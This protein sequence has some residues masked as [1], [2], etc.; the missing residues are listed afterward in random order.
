M[1]DKKHRS[2]FCDVCNNPIYKCRCADDKEQAIRLENKEFAETMAVT[3][4]PLS[5]EDY[6]PVY[7]PHED[8]DGAFNGKFAKR[9]LAIHLSKTHGEKATKKYVKVKKEESQAEFDNR[10]QARVDKNKEIKVK[11]KTSVVVVSAENKIVLSLFKLQQ[12]CEAIGLDY[13]FQVKREG[14][15]LTLGVYIL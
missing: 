10:Q 3:M 9:A 2:D 7:G 14:L 12:D 8:C 1:N 6:P 11:E 15:K 5:K 13:S 4:D